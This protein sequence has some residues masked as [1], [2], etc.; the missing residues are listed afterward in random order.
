MSIFNNCNPNSNGEK[1]VFD[2]LP[3][4]MTIFDVGCRRDSLFFNYPGIVHYFEPDP[5][6][7]NELK[8]KSGCLN[9]KSYF[10]SFGLA[11][12]IGS[13]D[14]FPKFQSFVDRKE[15]CGFDDSENTV[16]FEL[17]T[18]SDYLFQNHINNID[19]LKIDTEGLEL[20]VIRG[21]GD[22]VKSVR[23]IQFE[24]GGTFRDAGIKLKDVIAY[25]TE[26]NFTKFSY[27]SNGGLV[28]VIDASVDHYQY[29]NIFCSNISH[30]PM[31]F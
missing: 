8:N 17:K 24:Y 2:K 5:S 29:C 22:A 23:F 3:P 18:G 25:L 7:L 31:A 19:F 27:L 16:K 28:P 20:S 11:D 14:Y 10:N 9:L 1:R 13:F 4:G 26:M 15:S 30:R 21:F 12:K 6:S